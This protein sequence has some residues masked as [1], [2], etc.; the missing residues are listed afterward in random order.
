MATFWELIGQLAVAL[1]LGTSKAAG[2]LF[3]L[4]ILTATWS[5][6]LNNGIFGSFC[7]TW[8]RWFA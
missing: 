4:R 8:L 3:L 5:V 2:A 7:A 1:T 6:L